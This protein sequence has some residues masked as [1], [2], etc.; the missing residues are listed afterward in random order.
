M[1][2]KI[3]ATATNL[4]R[5]VI[6]VIIIGVVLVDWIPLFWLFLT[7]YINTFRPRK[8]GHQFPN[9]ILKWIFLN[10][11]VWILIK[12]SLK[13]VLKGPINNIPALARWQAIILINTG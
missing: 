10:E 3:N 9:D 13:F 7:M 1:I 2:I 5:L 4:G 6:I 11:N 12:I 8:N